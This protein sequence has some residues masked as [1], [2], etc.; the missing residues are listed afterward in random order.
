[1]FQI[2]TFFE[3]I[4]KLSNNLIKSLII[5]INVL[6]FRDNYCVVGKIKFKKSLAVTL[7]LLCFLILGTVSAADYD[8]LAGS[9]AAN[10]TISLNVEPNQCD[11]VNID[12]E[13]TQVLKGDNPQTFDGLRDKIE[14]AP[15]NSTIT[16]SKDNYTYE[17]P[18][19]IRVKENL[20][21]DG[22]Y[23]VFD[24]SFADMH[25]LFMVE[26]DNVVLK[27]I[28]FSNWALDES[29][30]LIQWFGMN[31]T[32]QNCY[33]INNLGS[34]GCAVEWS[35]PAGVMDEC[36]FE[37][38]T[39]WDYAGSLC[40]YAYEMAIRNS[41]FVNNQAFECAGAIYLAGKTTNIQDCRFRNCSS[42]DGGGG[43]IYVDSEYTVINNCTFTDCGAILGGA[44]YVDGDN[45]VI[46][47]STFL[48]N[49]A[50]EDGGAVYLFGDGCPVNNSCFKLNNAS[51]GG[52]I[53]SK[54]MNDFNVNNCTFED[55][56]AEYGGAVY[57][58]NYAVISNSIFKNNTALSAG[59]VYSD[60]M[61][62]IIDSLFEQNAA[63]VGGALVLLDDCAI[64]NSTF[65]N[66]MANTSGGAMAIIDELML[67]VNNTQFKG[68]LA[69]DGANNMALIV[70]ALLVIDDKT[71]SDSPLALKVVKL[72]PIYPESIS[73]GD[74]LYVIVYVDFDDVAMENGT[75]SNKL[76]GKE[77]S[78]PV[79]AGAAVFNITGLNPGNY[80]GLLTYTLDGYSNATAEYNFTVTKN[81]PVKKDI[82]IDAKTA[83]FVINYAQTYS[84]TVKDSQG[85]PV[86]GK[87]V[88]FQLNG[89]TVGSAYSNSKGVASFKI[90]SKM[91]K[92]AKAGTKKLIIV[93]K[94]DDIFNAAVKTVHVKINKEKTK[95]AAKKK[96]FKAKTKIKK[97]TVTLKNSK[98]KA[99]KKAKLTLKVNGKKYKAKTNKKGKATF[100]IKKL[101]KKGKYNAVIKFKANKYYKKASKKVK[102][103][104][105]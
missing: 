26:G 25:G 91:L 57:V 55:N 6:K 38:N 51:D 53:C 104:I 17:N 66:N 15:A 103:T 56:A 44:V 77:Y 83:S 65:L 74:T 78:A 52:A 16:I 87:N 72:L 99:I 89:K 96:T 23:T 102:L 34:I 31:G 93:S 80:T 22:N 92:A 41:T 43:A 63:Q 88:I 46:D 9:D 18:S 71:T 37:N 64:V 60:S 50:L 90:T 62:S 1:M 61:A 75:V 35:G 73:Y 20:T 94:E 82:I 48:A 21:I 49:F 100:K 59:A 101:S 105:K 12:T 3:K 68:N 39:A 8:S 24:G 29:Y 81:D 4:H 11:E 27:N 79:K 30:N 47:N 70:D 58:E 5:N 13:Q 76:D 33:F 19:P 67:E 28:I 97:Y 69:G 14:N 10:D 95:L 84:V 40:I 85:N 86:A 54:G 2:N 32:L 98:G 42:L 36:Y 45:N 7:L